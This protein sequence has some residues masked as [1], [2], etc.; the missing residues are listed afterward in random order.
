MRGIRL[1]PEERVIRESGVTAW[2]YVFILL[3]GVVV[4]PMLTLALGLL[5]QSLVAL[6][7]VSESTASRLSFVLA[8]QGVVI[9]LLLLT[10]YAVAFSSAWSRRYVLTDSRLVI[11]V[12][13]IQ[14]IELSADLT[15]I[16]EVS[17]HQTL[18][19][20]MLGYGNLAIETAGTQGVLV[21]RHVDAPH[22]WFRAITR[23]AEE[24]DTPRVPN[25]PRAASAPS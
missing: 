4:V 1:K 8:N 16:Q 10:L 13:I 5:R 12:G 21:V 9:G 18:V 15:R 22:E 17:M 24:S 25:V 20:R 23:S 3:G 2:Y 14:R 6:A 19:G 7:G 11:A